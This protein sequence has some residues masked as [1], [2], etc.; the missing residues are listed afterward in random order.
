MAE[1]KV[2]EC[3]MTS[4]PTEEVS[5]HDHVRMQHGKAVREI[6]KLTQQREA[7]CQ[8]LADAI[9]HRDEA[10]QAQLEAENRSE[11][12]QHAAHEANMAMVESKA[13]AKRAVDLVAKL[14]V[15]EDRLRRDNQRLCAELALAKRFQQLAK[16]FQHHYEAMHEEAESR[17]Q[18]W[19]AM[20]ERVADAEEKLYL[21][22]HNRYL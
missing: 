1:S 4:S 9:T 3:L 17:E 19:E 2:D 10:R 16:R 22:Y 15:L 7:M 13:E 21:C 8:L 6:H 18:E 14:A 12:H 5:A 20:A 11:V